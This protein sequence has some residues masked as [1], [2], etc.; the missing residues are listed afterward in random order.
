MLKN[1]T[2]NP[3]YNFIITIAFANQFC[4]CV[5][6]CVTFYFL[7]FLFTI[8]FGDQFLVFIYITFAFNCCLTLIL[9][10][11]FCFS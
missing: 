3:V 2:E 4:V 6:V 9:G 5:C 8:A 1:I 10:F 11:S 7:G